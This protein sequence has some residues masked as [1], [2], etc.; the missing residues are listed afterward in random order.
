MPRPPSWDT[1][2]RLVIPLISSVNSQ[3]LVQPVCGTRQLMENSNYCRPPSWLHGKFV[4]PQ[5][6]GQ[7]MPAQEII[8]RKPHIEAWQPL[9]YEAATVTHVM[10]H[11]TTR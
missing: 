2:I 5:G 11:L 7:L 1:K 10:V 9:Q 8:Y 4:T 6:Q 3:V